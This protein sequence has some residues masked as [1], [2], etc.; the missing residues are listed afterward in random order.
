MQLP[1]INLVIF[2]L[3]CW[4]DLTCTGNDV[5]ANSLNAI[6][7]AA[8]FGNGKLL[9][10]KNAQTKPIN[11]DVFFYCRNRATGQNVEVWPSDTNLNKKIDKSKNTILLIHGWVNSVNTRWIQFSLQGKKIHTVLTQIF[12]KKYLYQISLNMSQTSTFAPLVGLA[13]LH[14]STKSQHNATYTVLVASL[15]IR[16]ETESVQ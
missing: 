6:A 1:L 15:L 3:T 4:V 16:F 8:G 14:T 7:S 2:Y 5:F 9:N 10:D 11:Q 12:K 13:W